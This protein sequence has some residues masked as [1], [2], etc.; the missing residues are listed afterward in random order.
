MIHCPQRG[1]PQVR[2]G[3]CRCVRVE[4]PAPGCGNTPTQRY[5]GRPEPN[6]EIFR[7]PERPLAVD[8]RLH[9]ARVSPAAQPHPPSRPGEIPAHVR[10]SP[11]AGNP[12]RRELVGGHVEHGKMEPLAHGL[13]IVQVPAVLLRLGSRGVPA[14]GGRRKNLYWPELAGMLITNPPA[15]CRRRKDLA[16]RRT[17]RHILPAC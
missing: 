10:A 16:R 8:H 2:S 7:E 12:P 11:P 1:R 9:H 13:E 6:R 4:V 15:A 5:L 17:R 3:I 14:A